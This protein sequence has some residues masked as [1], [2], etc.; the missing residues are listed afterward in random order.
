MSISSRKN[1]GAS[2]KAAYAAASTSVTAAGTGDATLVTGVAVDRAA[3]SLPL[4][5]IVVYNIAATIANTKNLALAYKVEHAVDAAFTVATDL[6]GAVVAS[7]VVLN[8]KSDGSAQTLTIQHNI[9][10]SGAMQFVRI[11]FTPDMSNTATDTCV[12]SSAWIFAGM[13]ELPQ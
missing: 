5:A 3:I 6:P 7:A 8:G 11:K 13:N 9:D 1:I 10:L 4:S 12:I 2:L